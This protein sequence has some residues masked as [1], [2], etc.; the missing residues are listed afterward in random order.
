MEKK[1]TEDKR[2]GEKKTGLPANKLALR[3]IVSANR[4][5]NVEKKYD[6]T[7]STQLNYCES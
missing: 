2:R 1:A 3:C 4:A 7:V 6:P 5:F